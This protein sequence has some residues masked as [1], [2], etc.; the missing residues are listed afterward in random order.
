MNERRVSSTAG[1]KKGN[2]EIFEQTTHHT[3]PAV[4]RAKT[5]GIT[6]QVPGTGRLGYCRPENILLNRTRT[7]A[8][9]HVSC[10]SPFFGLSHI[11]L[12]ATFVFVKN[13]LVSRWCWWKSSIIRAKWVIVCYGP[14]VIVN[15]CNRKQLVG[16]Y[17]SILIIMLFPVLYCLLS[18]QQPVQSRAAVSFIT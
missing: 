16:T 14:Y 1:K 15:H 10:I 17:T 9:V 5:C 12:I 13:I 3:Y 4:S 7:V 6:A 11:L 8:Y 2:F 18:V